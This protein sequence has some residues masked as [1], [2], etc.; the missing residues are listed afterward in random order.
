MN[1]GNLRSK[2]TREILAERLGK[3]KID[4]AMIQE[5]QW[6]DNGEWEQGDYI[7]YVTAARR[8]GAGNKKKDYKVEKE[9]E[10]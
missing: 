2:E 1:V 5:T 8:N 7:F 9:L 3:M 4:I 6:G 10:D